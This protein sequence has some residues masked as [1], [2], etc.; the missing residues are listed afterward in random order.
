MPRA[1]LAPLN[2]NRR[3]DYEFVEALNTI[4]DLIKSMDSRLN[5][6]LR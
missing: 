3:R 4:D 5:V 1:V 2:A 6:L